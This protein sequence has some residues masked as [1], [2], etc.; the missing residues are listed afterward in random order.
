MAA[1]KPKGLGKG[2]SAII[3]D[4]EEPVFHVEQSQGMA[5]RELPLDAIVPG[6][7][8]PR[9]QFDEAYIAELAESI[10]TN[11]II[12][13]LVIRQLAQGRYE[14]IAGERRYRAARLAGLDTVPA[15]V[16]ELTDQKALEFAIIENVQRQ[17]LNPLE[18]AEGYRRLM[19]EFGH[20]QE[21]ISELIGKSR[22]HIANLLRL[23]QLPEGVKAHLRSGA[24]SMGHARALLSAPNPEALAET[25]I[26]KGLNVRQTEGLVKTPP[27]APRAGGESAALAPDLDI[28]VLE[29]A[30]SDSLHVTVSIQHRGQKGEIVLKYQ[31]LAELDG[32]L[33]KLAGNL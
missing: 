12:Q 1:A 8:Q 20:T 11:G 22:S 4:D 31:S 2:I 14:I 23:L 26:A 24:L 25:V 29:R 5:V 21:A 32:L 27:A 28:G 18:E 19:D 9:Q 30:L 3:A 7:Y 15:V 17:D 10:K 16:R 13:P 6:Q 33:R